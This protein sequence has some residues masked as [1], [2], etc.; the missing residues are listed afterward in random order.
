[1]SVWILDEKLIIFA[2]LISPSKM[3]LFEKKYQTFNTVF[4]HQ[5]KHCISGEIYYFSCLQ[6]LYA[7]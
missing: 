1:M 4:H 3:I 6:G 5:L 7:S 2:S